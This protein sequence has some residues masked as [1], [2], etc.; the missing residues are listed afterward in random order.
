MKRGAFKRFRHHRRFQPFPRECREHA[1][2]PEARQFPKQRDDDEVALQ[3]GHA[4]RVFG[5]GDDLIR[6]QTSVA[7]WPFVPWETR[8]SPGKK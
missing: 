1:Q 5:G 2:F 4:G 6:L 7:G 3:I 8:N